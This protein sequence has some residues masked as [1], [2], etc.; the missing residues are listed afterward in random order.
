MNY[1]KSIKDLIESLSK[2]PT[3][4]PRTAERFV[5]H[6]LKQ[7]QEDLEEIAKRIY[8][9]KKNIKVCSMCL[10]LSENNPCAICSDTKRDNTILCIVSSF[11]EMQ[12]IESTRSYNGLYY[13]I[14]KNINTDNGD[15]KEK[16]TLKKLKEKLDNG[17]IKEIILALSPTIEGETASLYLANILKPYKIKTTKLARG[18]PMGSD[19]EYADEITINNALKN[20]NEI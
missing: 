14:G 17:N 4:G 19:I 15:G 1:P 7:P 8:D 3:V 11:T 12:V 10:G 6:L 20:R 16:I 9:L 18:L 5:I 13:I 2:L